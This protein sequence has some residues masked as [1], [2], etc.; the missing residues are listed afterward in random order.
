M[1]ALSVATHRWTSR[2]DLT[3]LPTTVTVAPVDIESGHAASRRKG[4]VHIVADAAHISDGGE[5]RLV[6]T[7]LCGGSTVD[8]VEVPHEPELV[9]ANCSL[10]AALPQRPCV[11]YAWG[12]GDELLYIGSTVA[13][14]TR[15]RAHISSTPWWPEVR[16]LSFTEFATEADARQ[17]EAAAIW[18]QSS[19]YNREGTRA[20]S[21]ARSRNL[22]GDV[23]V[24]VESA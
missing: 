24:E 13:A 9:C 14:P 4:H 19:K 23:R 2:L 15:I 12:D 20:G 1:T 16:R 21:A 17:A 3:D 7:W 22:L 11:Y 18:E 6:A 5:T 10:A 8:A